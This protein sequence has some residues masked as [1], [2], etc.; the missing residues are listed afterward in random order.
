MAG[1]TAYQFLFD[2]VR[3]P[4]GWTVL[5]NGAAGGVGHFAV[6]FAKARGAEVFATCSGQDIGFVR[7]LGADQVID[8]KAERFE[9]EV[10]KV[11][12]VYDLI[13][14]ETQQRSFSILR[15]GGVLVSTLTEPDQKL[16]QQYGVR[17]LRYTAQP[18]GD[19]LAKIGR[20]IDTGRVT[21]AIDR[22]YP[23]ARAADAE[24][25]LEHH[26]VRGKIVLT[27]H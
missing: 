14:G 22:T 21:P 24:D 7:S 19:Q 20:L 13:A 9:D 16:C 23:L 1:L 26:H 11:D 8:Y 18:N 6:Q 3:L 10:E 4:T 12:L 27:V 2:H 17:G 25:W 5:V 15:R